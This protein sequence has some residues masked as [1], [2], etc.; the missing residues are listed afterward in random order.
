MTESDKKSNIAVALNYD[1]SGAPKVTAK[2]HGVLAERIITLAE[3]NDIPLRQDAG[4]VQVLASVPLD[5]EIP[6]QLYVAVAEVIAFAY[7]L[8]GKSPGNVSSDHE[9]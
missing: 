9:D 8:S 2:G 4:L 6:R 1:G 3:A 5:R 7:L